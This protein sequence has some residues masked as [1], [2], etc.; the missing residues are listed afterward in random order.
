MLKFHISNSFNL[1]ITGHADI[2]F[3]DVARNDDTQ[4]FIDP[5]LIEVGEDALSFRC[6]QVIQDYFEHLCLAYKEKQHNSEFL[7]HLGERNEARL[8]YGTGING[9]AKTPS[10]MDE[11]LNGLHD[12]IVR[13]IPLGGIIDIPLMM[14]RFAEDCMSDM[15]INVLYKQLSEF[16]LGQCAKYC[17][18]T[19]PIKVHRHFWD[20]TKH[21]WS[22]YTGDCLVLDGDMILLVPKKYVSTR[23][24]YSTSRFFMG[25]IATVLQKQRTSILNGKEVAPRKEDIRKAECKAFGSM[26]EATREHTKKMPHM[27]D[28]YHRNLKSEYKDRA[29]SDTELDNQVYGTSSS[30]TVA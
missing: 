2:D 21:S 27:L 6:Q 25:K 8:G 15:L 3:V 7:Y 26:I 22:L 9:K 1:S 4:L 29:M 14:P 13:G 28:D 19:E 20:D 10:G 30:E 16:T 18:K 11:T 17:I 24:Y 5:C 12:L 23:F